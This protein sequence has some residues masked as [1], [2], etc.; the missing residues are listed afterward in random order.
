M[1]VKT[2]VTLSAELLSALEAEAG[3]DNR[4]AFIEA[5]AWEYLELRKR[6]LRNQRELEL[7]DANSK[8]L[9]AEARDSLEYQ[10]S[11]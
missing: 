5:A 9:N 8:A 3:A 10:E 6:R 7:I 1:K 4:S 2:S 11:L